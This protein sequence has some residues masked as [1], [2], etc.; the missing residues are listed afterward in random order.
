MQFDSI[1]ELL[2]M[3]G[4]GVFVWAVYA[5]AFVVLSSLLIAPLRK[6]RQ[7]IIEQSM[8]QRRARADSK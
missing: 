7:F 2:T 5:I 4:H 6:K 3:G 1:S 8:R